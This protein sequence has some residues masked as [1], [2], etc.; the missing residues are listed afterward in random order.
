LREVVGQLVEV[1][2]IL[3]ANSIIEDPV[4]LTTLNASIRKPNIIGVRFANPSK[5]YIDYNYTL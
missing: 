1:S 2:H 3:S 5:R 4:M